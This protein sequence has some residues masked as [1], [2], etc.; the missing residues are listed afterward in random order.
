MANRTDPTATSV[1]GTNPQ[2]LVEKILRNRIYSCNYWKEHCFGLTAATVVDKAIELKY[3]GGTYGGNKKPTPFICLILKLLQIQPE[4]EIIQ[5]FIKNEDY[6]YVRI[7]GA[8]YLRLIGKPVEIFS[9]LEP[10]YNDYRK[11]RKRTDMGFVYTHVD[12]FIDELLHGDYSCDI[13]L[14]FLPK[15]HTLEYQGL[16]GPRISALAEELE[17]DE[18]GEQDE[19]QV[20]TKEEQIS[21]SKK[22][23]RSRSPRRRSD[24]DR[25][26]DRDRDR[27][28]KSR[29]RS[30]SRDRGESKRRRSRSRSRDRD[31]KRHHEDRN[32]DRDR[33]RDSG[34]SK[35]AETE[36]VDDIEA[37]NK[38][39][40]SLGL[41]PLGS[42]K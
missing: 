4:L 37:M 13:A 25:D 31:R 28:R 3:F 18:Q 1:H 8:F 22:R 29:S 30:R 9:S 33:D 35:E 34:R 40:A 21:S 38:L 39:R 17:A 5:E 36:P 26:R 27:R 23:D 19:N 12:E 20:A 11:A 15:R 42:K 24:S 2:F 32:R 14:S 10:L 41:K 6:K 16:L 7:L